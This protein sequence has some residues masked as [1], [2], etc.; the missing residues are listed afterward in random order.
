MG[1]TADIFKSWRHPRQ[2]MARRLA[3]GRREDRAL[4]FLM[5]GCLLIFVAQW[6]RLQRLAIEDPATSL[7]IRLG[8]ALLGW[9]FIMPLVLYALAGLSHLIARALGGQGNWFGARLA[10][11][12]AVLAAA[13]AWLING[14]VIGLGVGNPVQGVVGVVAL[15]GF[16]GIWGVSLFEAETTGAPA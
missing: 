15:A 12:W 5:A 7:E 8:G 10:L 16:L 9:L 1:I 4:I 11:F 13:P 6:P 2:V 14:L 3:E